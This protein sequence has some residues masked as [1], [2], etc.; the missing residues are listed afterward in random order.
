M[1]RRNRDEPEPVED[2]GEDGWDGP[3][4]SQ[5]KRDAD[6]L[7]ALGVRLTELAPAE[8]DTL[9]LPENLRDA[10]DLAKRITAHGGLYRQRQYIGKLMRNADVTAIRAALEARDL[11]QRLAAREFHRVESWRDRLVAEGEPAIEALL[12]T[13]P[14]LNA[15]RLRSLVS[16][17][18]AQ[19]DA[20]AAPAAARALF[21]LLRDALAP[22][23]AAAAS[24]DADEAAPD[25]GAAE[26]SVAAPRPRGR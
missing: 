16:A 5:R 1:G 21:K 2:D 10:I 22:C 12:A 11:Q 4:K 20:G 13:E 6:E 26:H 18:R 19:R 24:R 14:R 9:P 8:L 25:A 15:K 7:Q 17:A 3:S 23:A